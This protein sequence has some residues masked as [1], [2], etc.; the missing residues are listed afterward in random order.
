MSSSSPPPPVVGS[1]I[2]DV[3]HR[4]HHRTARAR[5]A[6]LIASSRSVASSAL[7]VSGRGRGGRGRHAAVVGAVTSDQ[8]SAIDG[9]RSAI[10]GG[11]AQGLDAGLTR[12][13]GGAGAVVRRRRLAVLGV[14]ILLFHL[15]LSARSECLHA[16]TRIPGRIPRGGRPAAHQKP[17]ARTPVP[18]FGA[19][20]MPPKLRTCHQNYACGSW[21]VLF[22]LKCSLLDSRPFSGFWCSGGR[23]PL[24]T[25]RAGL[26]LIII[27]IITSPPPQ[28][29]MRATTHHK[30]RLLHT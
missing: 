26:R 25:V 28:F 17:K 29:H 27:I 30:K 24:G 16:Y 15:V 2:G 14:A 3:R 6:S 21:H 18:F 8:R 9:R 20:K 12:G 4:L 19:K 22:F 5:C 11:D 13:G 23:L 10:D 1:V 7:V